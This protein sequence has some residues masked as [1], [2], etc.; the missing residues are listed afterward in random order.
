MKKNFVSSFF[1][2]GTMSAASLGLIILRYAQFAQSIGR[3]NL[4]WLGIFLAVIFF[5]A[6]IVSLTLFIAHPRHSPGSEEK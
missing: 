5:A 2:L 4:F 3:S 6:S 1:L